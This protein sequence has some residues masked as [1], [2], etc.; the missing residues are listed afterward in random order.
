LD[1]LG[2]ARTMHDEVERGARQ[3]GFLGLVPFLLLSVWLISLSP[4]HV[5]RAGT[6]SLLIAYGAVILSFLGGIRWGMAMIRPAERSRRDLALAMGPALIAWVSVAT[7]APYAFAV[8]AAA[9]AAQGASDT[10]AA[11]GGTAPRWYGRLRTTL[12]VIVVATM[13]LAFVA[14]G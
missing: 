10:L 4:D 6:V 1:T 5:W 2:E 9:F 3:I 14:T 8:L 11:H 13:I 12:T 7:P